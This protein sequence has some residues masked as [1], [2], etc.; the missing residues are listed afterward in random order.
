MGEHKMLKKRI[1]QLVVAV[2]LTVAIAGGGIVTEQI[3]LQTMTPVYA[4]GGMSGGGG[5]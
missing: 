4:C 1:V 3:G 5:C 2:A